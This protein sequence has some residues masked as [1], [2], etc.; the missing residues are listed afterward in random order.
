MRAQPLQQELNLVGSVAPKEPCIGAALV[1]PYV[2]PV[3]RQG[4][5]QAPMGLQY[6]PQCEHGVEAVGIFKVHQ[7]GAAED[8]VEG[9][10]KRGPQVG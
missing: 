3:G 1:E 10:P 7:D 8:A 9:T 6:R 4:H 2:G 5:E